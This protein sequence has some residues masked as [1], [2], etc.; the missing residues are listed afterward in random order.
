M[1][2]ERG[3]LRIVGLVVLLNFAEPALTFA[4]Q[5]PQ[6][7]AIVDDLQPKSDDPGLT[8]AAF[9]SDTTI[10]VAACPTVRR[11]ATCSFAFFRWENGVLRHSEEPVKVKTGGFIELVESSPSADGRRMF[12]DFND[13]EVP[14]FQHVLDCIRTVATLGMIADEDVN[15]EV[16]QVADTATRKTCFDWRR[17]F[18]STYYRMRA[19]AMSPSGEFV[20]ILLEN[21]LSIYRLPAV[22]EGPRA[23][24]RK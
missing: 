13:K 2:Y 12:F 19:A 8:T 6:P 20:A 18:P 14:K 7:V 22:C 10:E 9:L 11:D 16:V 24:R 21:K 23:T 5:L 1:R 4:L 17:T 15:R 3:I